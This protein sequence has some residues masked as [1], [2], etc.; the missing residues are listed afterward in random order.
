MTN[1]TG[2]GG[3]TRGSSG[4]TERREVRAFAPA[5][6]SNLGTG[7]D[8][9]G[10]A[11][12]GIGDEVVARLVPGSGVRIARITGDEGR[13]PLES[14][15]NTAGIAATSTLNKAGLDLGIELE[16]HKGMPLGSGLGSSAASA[17]AAAFAVNG[18]IGKPLRRVDLVDA[19]LDA[20]EAVSGRHA[21]NVAP[22]LLG[23]LV[24]VRSIAPL[25]LVRLPVPEGLHVALVTPKHELLTREARAILPAQ[26]SLGALVRNS[27]SLAAFVSACYSG[28]MALLARSIPDEIVTP[29]RASLIPGCLAVIESALS[30]GALGSGISGA[31]PSMFALCRSLENAKRSATAMTGAFAAEGLESTTNISPADGPGARYR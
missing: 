21:D 18:L 3:A 11:I 7:F 24:L 31:G 9:L 28:D 25:D 29:A 17:V 12:E 13:L 8:I 1:T 6:L 5:S 15:T 2:Q 27:A 23:G 20:E 10:L 22:S 26:V 14:K 16:I 19:C 4:T 30:V